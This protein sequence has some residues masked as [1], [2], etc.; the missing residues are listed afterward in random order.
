MT[1]Y[2]DWLKGLFTVR[3]FGFRVAGGCGALDHS[4]LVPAFVVADFIHYVIDQKE[5]SPARLEQTRWIGRVGHIFSDEPGSL[6]TDCEARLAGA[7]LGD[8]VYCFPGIAPVAVFDR[9][10]YSFVQRHEY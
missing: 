1:G 7:Q 9:V 6:I 3:R 8:N 4:N 5:A 2:Q 10:D